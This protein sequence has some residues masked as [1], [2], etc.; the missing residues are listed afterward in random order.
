MTVFTSHSSVSVLEQCARVFGFFVGKRDGGV[1]S[2]DGPDIINESAEERLGSLSSLI[3]DELVE[4]CAEIENELN[5]ID[6]DN[7]TADLQDLSKDCVDNLRFA[8]SRFNRLTKI[9][10]PARLGDS[11]MDGNDGSAFSVIHRIVN[12]MLVL[13]KST[14]PER[15]FCETGLDNISSSAYIRLSAESNLENALGCMHHAISFQLTMDEMRDMAAIKSNS[16]LLIKICEAIVAGPLEASSFDEENSKDEDAAELEFSLPLKLTSLACLMD[17]YLA[18]NFDEIPNLLRLN[19]SSDIPSSLTSVVTRLIDIVAFSSLDDISPDLVLQLQF[20]TLDLVAGTHKLIDIGLLPL[21]SAALWYACYSGKIVT[22][23][24]LPVHAWDSVVEEFN[25][26][27]L[28]S[29]LASLEADRGFDTFKSLT[30]L[31]CFGLEQACF[32][33]F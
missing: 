24:N 33:L 20:K 15:S 22:H 19:I 16:D 3:M 25:Y 7:S 27:T 31:W 23:G 5:V 6:V 10:S 12:S 18:R 11:E 9:I 30:R 14:K 17:M 8:L 26:S 28:E 21:D 13:L 29:A 32:C 4:L 1:S 2:E